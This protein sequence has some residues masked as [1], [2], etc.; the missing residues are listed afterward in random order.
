MKSAVPVVHGRIQKDDPAAFLACRELVSPMFDLDTPEPEQR[1]EYYMNFSVYDFGQMQLSLAEAPA[2]ILS[3]SQKYVALTGTD[4]FLVQYYTR[5]GF[6]LATDGTAVRLAP[7]DLVVM[8]LSRPVTIRS[9]HIDNVSMILRRSLLA[10]LLEQPEHAHGLVL[11]RDCET[12]VAVRAYIEDLVRRAADF[13]A[14]QVD[15]E[16]HSAAALIAGVIG[17]T[18]ETHLAARAE[19]RKSQFRAIVRWIDEHLGSSELGAAAIMR[20]FHVSRATLY[21]M[22]DPSDGIRNYIQARRLESVYRDLCDPAHARQRISTIF[23]RWGFSDH[24]SATRAFRTAY[25]LSPSEARVQFSSKMSSND[26]FRVNSAVEQA[27]NSLGFEFELESVAT[28]S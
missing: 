24:T 22:F 15:A 6:T 20:Q 13:T 18:R 28:S 21:R 9:D 4:Q 23:Y 1:P 8:D 25:G 27:F 26:A 3:R 2:S 12:N 16:C 17:A 7:C 5:G 11:R 10:P 19:L 14:E